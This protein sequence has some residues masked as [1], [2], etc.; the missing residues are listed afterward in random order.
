M[1]Y[2]VKI[3]IQR[4]GKFRPPT[5]LTGML[6][7]VRWMRHCATSWRG[8]GFYSRLAVL[9]SWLRLSFYGKWV[10]GVSRGG[11]DKGGRG[12]WLTTLPSS[13]PIV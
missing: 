6:A 5:V 9:W 1:T 8:R 11:W 7:E 13:Q 2:H 4:R 3:H 10:L 12:V